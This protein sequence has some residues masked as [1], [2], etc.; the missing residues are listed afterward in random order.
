[1]FADHTHPD[2]LIIGAGPA[3]LSAASTAASYGLHTVVIDAYDTIGG[4]IWR[5]M[6]GEL[7][8][9]AQRLPGI[10]NAEA[11]AEIQRFQDSGVPFF[12]QTRAWHI[13]DD[14]RV[15]VTG[16]KGTS[17][18]SPARILLATGAQ[19]RPFPFEGWTLPGVMTVGAAQLLLKASAT[20]P[21]QPVWL[22]GHGPLLLLYANQL[23][24]IGGQIAGI[25]DTSGPRAWGPILHAL[26]KAL[27]YG[28]RDVANGIRLTARIH[29]AKIPIF[30]G[31]GN[32]RAHGNNAL[33]AISFRDARGNAHYVETPCLLV[34]HGLEPGL[35]AARTA[36]CAVTWDPES[37]NFQTIHD[38]WGETTIPHL[39]IVGDGARIGGAQAAIARGHL[40]A[41]RIA[42]QLGKLSD[43]ALVQLAKHPQKIF[44]ATRATRKLID[45]VYRPDTSRFILTDRTLICRCESVSAGQ[46]REAIRSGLHAPDQIKAFT[47]AGMGACQGQQCAGSLN[48]MVAQET[49]RSP[50][51]VGLYRR[52]PPFAPLTLGELCALDEEA[53]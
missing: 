32:L 37:G 6:S 45:A 20:V 48:A 1:M 44:K 33:T 40:S 43:N 15:F 49:G 9:L 29:C 18:L 42:N 17:S 24:A 26:P 38:F 41:L 23:M 50:E 27:W 7:Q 47:R 8:D 13:A 4:M 14:K 30:H 53:G 34:H 19:E 11:T 51:T 35:Q 25:L 31:I 28:W 22:C 12:G 3:G 39:F 16:P 10:K 36:D 46:V 2:L 5:G 52:R 21:A